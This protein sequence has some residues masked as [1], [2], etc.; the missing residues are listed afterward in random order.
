MWIYKYHIAFP[1]TEQKQKKH[2]TYSMFLFEDSAWILEDFFFPWVRLSINIFCSSLTYN[3]VIFITWIDKVFSS[4][5][6]Q[7]QFWPCYWD[8]FY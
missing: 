6:E 3:Y 5:N 7:K 2:L 1:Y 4:N 8:T